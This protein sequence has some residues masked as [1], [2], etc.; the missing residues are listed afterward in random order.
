MAVWG[1]C[2]PSGGRGDSKFDGPGMRGQH[3]YDQSPVLGEGAVRKVP[4]CW[5]VKT[6]VLALSVTGVW[7]GRA[8]EGRALVPRAENRWRGRWQTP[9]T[10]AEDA[11]VF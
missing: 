7:E 6:S 9:E 2:T 4:V 10:S 5:V 11:A 8:K 3:H 1:T